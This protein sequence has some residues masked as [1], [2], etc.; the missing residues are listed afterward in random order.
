MASVWVIE[1]GS[2]S[3]YRVCGVYDSREKAERVAE[4]INA[5]ESYDEAT[6]AEWPM[7]P[8][9]FELNAGMRQYSVLMLRDGS[10]ESARPYDSRHVAAKEQDIWRRSKAP[11]YL[12]KGVQDCLSSTVWATDEKHAIKIVNERRIQL[13]ASGEWDRA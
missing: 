2:Y 4:W 10:V 1:Q 3:D 11:A 5:G 7:N 9:A 13:L 12:G 8:A 6:V